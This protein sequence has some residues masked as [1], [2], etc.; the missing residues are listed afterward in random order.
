MDSIE[1]TGNLV[2]TYDSLTL[3]PT[4]L[5]KTGKMSFIEF[6]PFADSYDSN[7][8]MRLN[9]NSASG[10]LLTDRSFV[11]AKY[12]ADGTGG[13][14]I[15][16]SH[17]GLTGIFKNVQTRVGTAQLPALDYVSKLSTLDLKS[18]SDEKKDIIEKMNF[19][20]DTVSDTVSYPFSTQI[21]DQ[22][23][24]CKSAIPLA[25]INGGIT[26]DILLAPPSEVLNTCP[27]YINKY[28]ISDI[29]YHACIVEPA[30]EIFE[31]H[32]AVLQAGGS[33][34]IYNEFNQVYRFNMSSATTNYIPLA[35]EPVSSL[36]ACHLV[37]EKAT[38][39]ASTPL[40]VKTWNV[41]IGNESFPQVPIDVGVSS[42]STI[43]SHFGNECLGMSVG[44]WKQ[45]QCN[46]KV[47]DVMS[48]VGT[49]LVLPLKTF[50]DAPFTGVTNRN[51]NIKLNITTNTDESAKEFYLVTSYDGEIKISATNVGLRV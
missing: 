22:L 17:S 49:G 15:I 21:Y 28:T 36:N 12:L 8:T 46:P 2:P 23:Y 24:S 14:N 5:I 30:P 9:V 26:W 1:Q 41:Q 27:A 4:E 11:T 29:K 7:S 19:S 31:Q 43:R 18:E 25:F 38:T 47:F 20:G 44:G 40:A 13:S 50:A 37:V 10:Y 16:M 35:V 42:G 48:T 6:S 32:R 33:L 45:K 39:H 3:A 51:G 34:T